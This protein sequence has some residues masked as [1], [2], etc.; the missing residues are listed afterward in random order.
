MTTDEQWITNGPWSVAMS[1]ETARSIARQ[2]GPSEFQPA[3]SHPPPGDVPCDVAS[4]VAGAAADAWT[5]WDSERGSFSAG[6]TGYASGPSYG[7]FYCTGKKRRDGGAVETCTHAAD[8]HAGEIAVRLTIRAVDP[9]FLV[10]WRSIGHISLGESR[11]RVES[12][13]GQA[14]NG[15][16]VLQRYGDTVQG[17][18]V[19]HHAHVIVTF[20][21][22]RVGEL[23]FSTPYYRTRTGFGVGSTMPKAR[24]WHG[25]VYDAWNRG[26]PCTCWVKVGLG[27]QSLPATTANFLKPWF[28]IYT[29]QGSVTRFYF[30]LKFVD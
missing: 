7:R 22:N 27:A 19:L 17:Y 9:P 13:Y 21:G 4:S 15:Y 14:G 10:P 2:V 5:H 16:H 26:K 6:W 30:A 1:Y 11:A 24:V 28:F 20:Y 12:D 29:R 3:D 8:R 23:E 25:F 18:Y